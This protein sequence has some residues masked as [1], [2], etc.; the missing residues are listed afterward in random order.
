MRHLTSIRDLSIEEIEVLFVIADKMSR[1]LH[2]SH[3]VLAGYI[4]GSLFFEPSTRTRLS[5]ESAMNR[6]GGRVLT[7]ADVKSSSVVKGESLADSVRI[8][9]SYADILVLR[10]PLQGAARAASLFSPVPVIN[11]GDGGHE[12]P[13]QTLCDLYTLRHA[14]GRIEGL[15]VLLY[16]DL[17][18]G[19]TTHSLAQALCRFG[20]DVLCVAEPGLELP[21]SVRRA[22]TGVEGVA[23]LDV[24]LCGGDVF[25]TAAVRGLLLTA[26]GSRWPLREGALDVE[27][28]TADALYVTRLQSER[29]SPAEESTERRLNP[30]DRAFLDH[31]G[32]GDA[33]VLHP[34]P[35]VDEIDHA[36]DRDPRGF[37]FKQAALGVPIRMALV[38]FL[39]GREI[40]KAAPP[41]DP[42]LLPPLPGERCSQKDC[43]V[44]V[45]RDDLE[46]QV[47]EDSAG[48]RVC[49]FCDH[50][51]A[52]GA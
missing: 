6:L 8:V 42:P 37:Y 17:K 11:A 22:C 24:D 51:L 26:D 29:L 36:V 40:M 41:P 50:P 32:F 20:A 1:F 47:V 44:N 2:Q 28:L 9:G 19:R 45:E 49:A 27:A 33:V 13:T 52:E 46:F 39:L 35:R 38:S 31:S 15:R 5:F 23:A 21:D 18:Y 14:K 10:H 3:G 16:G 48:E 30:V 12:H 34:L 7:M 4:M 43:I 25:G